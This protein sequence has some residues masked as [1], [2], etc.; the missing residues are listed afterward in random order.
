MACIFMTGSA[1]LIGR[2]LRG[3]L[4]ASGRAV[5]GCDL[6]SDAADEKYDLRDANRV[7]EAMKDCSGVIH[8]GAL[9]RVVWGQQYP[10]LCRSINVGGARVVMRAAAESA[11][12]PWL[13]FAGSREV[14]GT[15]ATLPCL[16][17]SP[18]RPEN[19]YAKTK[20]KAEKMAMELRQCGNRSA[21]L[22]FSNVFGS[23]DDYH[24]RVVPAFARASA[25]G[26]NLYV[27]GPGGVYDFTV[28]D[29]VV[30]A[31][32]RAADALANGIGDL[33]PIDI[34]TGRAVSLMEL[35]QM[36]LA[37]GSGRIITKSPT[38]F[39]PKRFQGDPR[40]AQKYLGWRARCVLEN[41]MRRL[42]GDFRQTKNEHENIKSHSWLSALV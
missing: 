38:G 24:D 16:A 34:V 20:L 4:E 22:R 9:S 39:Y 12:K 17:D 18:L 41:A 6:R 42:V 40:P 33:P 35:A 13:L 11:Q 7:R 10:K 15:P 19:I 26:G 2:A 31:V 29:D 30:A 32:L 3:R 8:L 5:V 27:R 1:G 25:S 28:L 23:A 21:V 37:A 14:Y 36:A